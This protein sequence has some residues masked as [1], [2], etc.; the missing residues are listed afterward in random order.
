MKIIRTV[1]ALRK[2]LSRRRTDG[3]RIGF[4]PTMGYFHEGHFSLMR[5]SVKENDVTVVSLFV[6]PLQFGP[7]EDLAKYPRDL[8]RDRRMAGKAGVDLLFVPSVREMYSSEPLAYIEVGRIGAALCGASRPGHF[9]GVATVV[10]KFL[11]IVQP[12]VMYL[13]QKDAQQS[14]VIRRMVLDLN[15]PVRLVVAPT[16]READGLAMSSRN[17]YLSPS[18]RRE[19]PALYKALQAARRSVLSGESDGKKIISEIKK[20]ILEETNASIEYVSLVE[21]GCF[22][23]VRRIE[24]DVLIALAA[25]F[26]GTRLIDNVIVRGHAKR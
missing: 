20:L 25:R 3:K 15:F 14:A 21:L 6:N 23:P 2:E 26:G 5:R 22:S 12:E 1:K 18:E 16:V 7:R 9:R 10:A 19:A 13:G 17:V 8:K 24:G 11:N 4:V